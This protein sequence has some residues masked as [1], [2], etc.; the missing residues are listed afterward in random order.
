MD[1]SAGMD[2]LQW[3]RYDAAMQR[4]RDS[5]AAHRA[6]FESEL[7]RA[8]DALAE[9]NRRHR[10]NRT[11]SATDGR[12]PGIEGTAGA[13]PRRVRAAG[14]PVQSILNKGG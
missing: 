13:Q 1:A 14:G 3:A 10:A 11:A 4:Y 8:K 2:P 6:T 9:L 7:R 12:H 5:V